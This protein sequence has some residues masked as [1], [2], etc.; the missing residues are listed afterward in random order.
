M[1]RKAAEAGMEIGAYSAVKP[2]EREIAVIQRLSDYPSVVAEAGRS[3]SPALIANYVYDL[4]KEYNPFYHDCSCMKVDD[5][6]VR[7]F[8]LALSEATAKVIRSGMGLLG[9]RVPERM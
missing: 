5:T 4:V 8:R 6:C 2:G 7:S 3:Y 9:I 1:L